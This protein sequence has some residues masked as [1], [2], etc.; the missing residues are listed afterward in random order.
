LNAR[1]GH[2]RE[3]L[4]DHP[5]HPRAIL[6][7]QRDCQVVALDRRFDRIDALGALTA[8]VALVG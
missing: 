1:L 8:L 2:L 3:V 5:L 6:G 7:T 4:L